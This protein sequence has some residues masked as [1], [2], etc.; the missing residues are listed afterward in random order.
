M[1]YYLANNVVSGVQDGRLRLNEVTIIAVLG[2]KDCSETL[3]II[4]ADVYL[5][6]L[7]AQL[8]EAKGTIARLSNE[9]ARDV[10]RDV[11]KDNGMACANCSALRQVEYNHSI[12]EQQLSEAKNQLEEMKAIFISLLNGA[13]DT[14]MRLNPDR[15]DEI[16]ALRERIKKELVDEHF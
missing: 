13:L 6:D 3:K 11:Q 16:N 1:S 2:C 4:D 12:T 15:K 14:A 9:Q 7:K 5:S 8:A 10:N